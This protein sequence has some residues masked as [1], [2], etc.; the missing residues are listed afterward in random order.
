M[1]FHSLLIRL[2]PSAQL[3]LVQVQV[4]VQR[5]RKWTLPGTCTV[6]QVI[7]RTV[8][9]QCTSGRTFYFDVLRLGKSIADV[10]TERHWRIGAEGRSGE[11]K[12]QSYMLLI[13][14]SAVLN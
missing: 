11:S 3:Y 8:A 4:L 10:L 14:T 12:N 2:S 9:R 6:R 7:I 1:V 5:R 13:C